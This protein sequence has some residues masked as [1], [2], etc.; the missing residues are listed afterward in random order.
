MT[1][2]LTCPGWCETNHS[3]EDFGVPFIDDDRVHEKHF[4]NPKGAYLSAWI[5]LGKDGCIEGSGFTYNIDESSDPDDMDE[6]AE[7]CTSAA[8]FMRQLR[9]A[10]TTIRP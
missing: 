4:G 7:W 1:T 9:D 6:V 8:S 3:R 2:V 5:A 10:E